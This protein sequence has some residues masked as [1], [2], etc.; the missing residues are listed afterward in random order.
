MWLDQS[1]VYLKFDGSDIIR[2]EGKIRS[3]WGEKYTL[4]IRGNDQ[5]RNR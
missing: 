3:W 2:S 4:R 5:V 1:A